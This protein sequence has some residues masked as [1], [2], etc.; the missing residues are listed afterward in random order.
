MDF[1]FTWDLGFCIL[2]MLL[3]VAFNLLVKLVAREEEGHSISPLAY[4]SE[5]PYRSLLLAVSVLLCA[6]LLHLAGRLTPELALLMGMSADMVA[7]RMR[8]RA[9]VRTGEAIDE[10]GQKSGV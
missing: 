9:G 2:L 7:D 6:V 8:L 4:L 5:R 3:G 1:F 10:I